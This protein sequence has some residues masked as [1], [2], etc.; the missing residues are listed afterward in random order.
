MRNFRRLLIVPPVACAAVLLTRAG[1]AVD[2]QA[3]Y[4]SA[5]GWQS[6]TLYPVVAGVL[7]NANWPPMAL[8]LVP[9]AWMPYP[10]ALGLWQ[11]LQVGLILDACRRLELKPWQT[12]FALLWTPTLL[13]VG[14]GQI[15]GLV[16]WLVVR[17]WLS[18]RPGVWLGLAALAKPF[19]LLLWVP[20]VLRRDA[21]VVGAA[22]TVLL[23]GLAGS[24]L[25]GGLGVWADWRSTVGPIAAN[26]HATNLSIVGALMRAE[27]PTLALPMVG[28]VM[29]FVVTRSW[30]NPH[31]LLPAAI[32]LSPLGWQYYGLVLLPLLPRAT[33]LTWVGLV[34]VGLPQEV[35]HGVAGTAGLLILTF[36]WLYGHRRRGDDD[37][38][39]RVWDHPV[40]QPA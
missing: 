13:C 38:T 21:R 37:A 6:G 11:A 10:V 19:L 40:A 9:L 22:L 20:A 14:Q 3:F 33:P 26:V 31:V 36:G 24:F 17:A 4:A 34:L 7:P 35:T 2:F 18:D 16:A 8:A 12:V 1:R 25:V 15:S 5:I 28:A 27:L 29:T 30:R 23:A 39:S 32:L